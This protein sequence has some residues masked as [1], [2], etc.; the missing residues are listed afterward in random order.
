MDISP[1]TIHVAQST[2]DDLHTRL[3]VTRWPDAIDGAGWEYGTSLTYMQELTAYWQ[4]DFDWRAQEA[5]LNQFPQFKTAIDGLGLHFIYARGK[6]PH[7]QPLLLTHGWPDSFYRFH[8][9]IPLLTDP[10]AHGGNSADAFDV[11]VPSIPGYGFSDKPT[12]PGM[13]AVRIADLFATLMTD[14]LGYQTFAAHGGDW[15]STITEKLA[16]THADALV[17]IHLTDVPYAHIFATPQDQLSDAEQQY[18]HAGQQWSTQE[19]AYAMIQGSKPQTLAYGMTD[20]PV[21]MA[22]WIIEKFRAWG[23]TAGAIESRFSKDELL[24]NI[25]IYW[26]TETFNSAARLYYESQHAR[27]TSGATRIDVPTGVAIFPR[28]LVA[29]P[30]VFAE[31]YFNVQHWT[32]MPRGGH[33]AAWEEPELLA[34]DLRA[35]FRTLR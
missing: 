1:F 5:K 33:F 4:S 11:V 30:R 12:E 26:A 27:H 17:G 10:T 19:G 21:G 25:M 14:V 6:G 23:D 15:G 18:V 29:A 35:F 24:T 13:D 16:M 3:A 31:R 9:L 28:D 22:A 7:A 2:L 20:S 8:K 32:E 34:E